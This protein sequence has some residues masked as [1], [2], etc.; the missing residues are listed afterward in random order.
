[1]KDGLKA[2]NLRRQIDKTLKILR[3]ALPI[4]SSMIK[5]RATPC[6]PKGSDIHYAKS[7]C[8]SNSPTA[9][10]SGTSKLDYLIQSS[11]QKST[12]DKPVTHTPVQQRRTSK[13]KSTPIVWPEKSDVPPD[14]PVPS[15]RQE[16]FCIEKAVLA[17]ASYAHEKRKADL[18]KYW[19][20]KG[21]IPRNYHISYRYS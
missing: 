6:A 21:W 8:N 4:I 9:T 2:T 19:F 7:F 11:L 18:T 20:S 17:F 15:D 3:E 16:Q 1:M 14:A 5:C 10:L 13:R 12:P